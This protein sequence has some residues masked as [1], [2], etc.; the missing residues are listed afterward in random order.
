MPLTGGGYRNHCLDC[1]WSL[2]VDLEPGDRANP[3]GGP[4]APIALDQHSAKGHMIVHRWLQCGYVGRNRVADQSDDIDRLTR[5][6]RR[7]LRETG[8]DAIAAQP[9]GDVTPTTTP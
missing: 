2:H 9:H 6:M 1:L 5:S 3:C 8:T 7:P 4:M